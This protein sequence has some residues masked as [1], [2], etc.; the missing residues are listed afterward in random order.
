M[1]RHLLGPSLGGRQASIVDAWSPDDFVIWFSFLTD[2]SIRG[3]R[4]DLN[5]R[6]GE[7]SASRQH[8]CSLKVGELKSEGAGEGLAVCSILESPSE[9]NSGLTNILSRVEG[10]VSCRWSVGACIEEP[11]ERSGKLIRV[12][13]GRLPGAERVAEI[14]RERRQGPRKSGAFSTEGKV[15]GVGEDSPGMKRGQLG[16]ERLRPGRRV[17]IYCNDPGA[18]NTTLTLTTLLALGGCGV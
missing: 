17:H 6:G 18:G 1:P 8:D 2:P 12:V 3:Q 5:T 13:A 16:G 14:H 15:D 7:R 10:T 4:L 9:F 11:F